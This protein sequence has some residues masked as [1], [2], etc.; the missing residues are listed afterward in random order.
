[1]AASDPTL[2][3]L[4]TPRGRARQMSIIDFLDDPIPTA[5]RKK[6]T[7]DRGRD[8]NIEYGA[9]CSRR[10]RLTSLPERERGERKGER[11]RRVEREIP[12]ARRNDQRERVSLA[13]SRKEKK[14]KEERRAR[15]NPERDFT[16]SFGRRPLPS[17]RRE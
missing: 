7:R 2:V 10:A 6:K 9:E 8:Y 13:L 1:V 15:R 11:R 4:S 3:N 16:A 5:A 17:T 12:R 14:K